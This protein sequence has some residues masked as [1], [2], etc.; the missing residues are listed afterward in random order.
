MIICEKIFQVNLLKNI[1]KL[2]ILI[3]LY[4]YSIG[5]KSFLKMR[6]KII[7]YTFHPG[8]YP[9]IQDY[10]SRDYHQIF[11]TFS[12]WNSPSN[13]PQLSIFYIEISEIFRLIIPHQ[14]NLRKKEFLLEFQ[15]FIII[16]KTPWGFFLLR[17]II[18]E[19]CE[20]FRGILNKFISY[21]R[22]KKFSRNFFNHLWFFPNLR[23]IFS[24]HQRIFQLK[25]EK[26][27][28]FIIEELLKNLS[29]FF[30]PR[31]NRR[32]ELPFVFRGVKKKV[33]TAPFFTLL[34]S[35]SIRDLV[36]QYQTP[37]PMKF[38]GLILQATFWLQRMN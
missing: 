17:F 12:D 15:K 2:N 38:Q 3:P 9:L 8:F 14:F 25:S 35:T 13:H 32:S 33:R 4:I 22:R 24:N 21:L 1:L 29:E 26:D 20:N 23:G 37:S 18:I 11:S 6:K 16:F 28:I 19:I 10:S 30:H 27:F 7:L 31:K 34:L 5:G 36:Y